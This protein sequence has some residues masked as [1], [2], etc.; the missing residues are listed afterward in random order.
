[1][2][3]IVDVVVADKNLVSI[4]SSVKAARPEVLSK[5]GPFIIRASTDIAF[6]KPGVGKTEEGAVHSLDTVIEIE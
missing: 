1:M 5:S 3:N 6:S 4:S 2:S